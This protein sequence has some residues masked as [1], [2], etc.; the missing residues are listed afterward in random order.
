M[1]LTSDEREFLDLLRRADEELKG[2]IFRMVLLTSKHGIPFLNAMQGPALAGDREAVQNII[3][4]WEAK[5]A[6]TQ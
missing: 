3:Q 5:D 1:I 4:E 6:T 2:I